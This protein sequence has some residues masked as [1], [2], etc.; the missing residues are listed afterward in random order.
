[1]VS[2]PGSVG[3][4]QIAVARAIAASIDGINGKAVIAEC[5]QARYR[6]CRLR[7]E[8]ELLLFV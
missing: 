8:H 7:L 3:G 1:M 2:V 4:N 5:R 6:I